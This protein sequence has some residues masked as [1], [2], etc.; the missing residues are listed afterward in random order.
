MGSIKSTHAGTLPYPSLSPDATLVRVLPHLKSA[1][2]LSLGQ[3]CDDDC[4]VLLNKKHLH[5]FKHNQPLI[6]GY[7]NPHDGLW[8]IPIPLTQ[9]PAIA[10][11][12]ASVIIQKKTPRKTLVQFYHAAC[13]SPSRSTF[14][15]AIRNGNFQSWPGL[16]ASLATKYLSATIP[17]RLGHM[18][19]ERQ[20]LQSTKDSDDD[21]FP[22]S[23]VPNLCTHEMMASLIPYSITSKAFGDFPGKFP[24]TSSRG[25]QYFFSSLQL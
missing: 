9:H 10:H 12:K 19:Q 24:Y 23:E 14:I 5:V 15:K 17:T 25:A 18:N 21:T 7:R 4:N 6:H 3:I 1:S 2:L 22:P 11:H 20:N 8:D 13:F 16:T